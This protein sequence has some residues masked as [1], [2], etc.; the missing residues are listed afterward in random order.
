MIPKEAISDDLPEPQGLKAQIQ[1][2]FFDG[3]LEDHPTECFPVGGL[4]PF[5]NLYP[6]L[7]KGSNLTYFED[8][9]RTCNWLGLPPY[10]SHEK[11]IWKGNVALPVLG[12]LI[13]HLQTGM[14]LQVPSRERSHTVDGS[15]I[16]LAPV[17]VDS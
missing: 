14:I 15:E 6:N 5:F 11:V 17:E 12:G 2:E 10:I 8:H 13:N 9:A 3:Y 7:G 1:P 16:R 4:K